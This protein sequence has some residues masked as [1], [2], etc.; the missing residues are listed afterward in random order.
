MTLS[1]KRHHL[2]KLTVCVAAFTIALYFNYEAVSAFI[3]SYGFNGDCTSSS[4]G[5]R[6]GDVLIKNYQYKQID[7]NDVLTNE[8]FQL[9]NDQSYG[10]FHDVTT[11]QWKLHQLIVS[12]HE[13]YRNP[14]NPLEFVPGRAKNTR[15]SSYNSA[16]AFYGSNYEP[17]FSC[18]F[19]R[20]I[21]GNGNGDG[22][23]WVSK[24]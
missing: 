8:T 14:E 4:R 17:N 21:G 9:A 13:R 20:R 15:W 19:E 16:E 18:A 6:G 7:D 3:Q 10:F 24:K 11:E 22:P 5:I 2:A 1:K 12:K 23:K